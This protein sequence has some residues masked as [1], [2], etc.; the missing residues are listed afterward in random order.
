MAAKSFDYQPQPDEQL[1]TDDKPMEFYLHPNLVP[2]EVHVIWCRG[3]E[4]RL[5]KSPWFEYKNYLTVLSAMRTLR[6]DKVSI[7][8]ETIPEKDRV[9]Y[10][11]WLEWLKMDYPWLYIYN[12]AAEHVSTG[13]EDKAKARW[14]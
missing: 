10:H 6:P 12:L 4:D 7:Y 5:K 8:F 13:R 9:I 2:P 14:G 11:Q 3:G 1:D